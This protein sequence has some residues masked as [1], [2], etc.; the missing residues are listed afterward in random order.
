DLLAMLM[1]ARD[2]ETG[3]AMTDAQLRDEVMTIVT[4]GHE[5]TANAMS[6]TLYL[7]SKHPDVARRVEREVED[8]LGERVPTIADLGKMPY[9]SAVIQ[10]AMRV[11]PPVW[12]IE[13]QAAGDDEIAGY[14]VAK[15][16]LVGIF[17]YLL[18]RHPAYWPNP[19]GFDPERFLPSSG[20]KTRERPRYAYLP[21][22]AGPRVCIG[23]AFALME[24]QILL[25][26]IVQRHRLELV[27][28][29]RIVPE[30]VV[31][32]R[33][34]DGMRM[35]LVPKHRQA[36]RTAAAPGAAVTSCQP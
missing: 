32:L 20:P 18:H 12:G 34:R 2:E 36:A 15:N 16:T 31:T 1:E 3:E 4:A 9:G 30:P 26:M 11:F 6:W 19:E 23:N 13:R 10:E 25:S 22:G 24:A 28:G 8:V 35:T 33:P 14:S 17:P 29:A 27:A 7:L 21:F 5:T